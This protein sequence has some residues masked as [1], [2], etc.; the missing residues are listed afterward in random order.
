MMF[1]LLYDLLQ[2]LRIGRLNLFILHRLRNKLSA[3]INHV[4]CLPPGGLISTR[5]VSVEK[6]SA[7][8]E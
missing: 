6:L 8:V 4:R 7:V 2:I 5:A 3:Y 1:L